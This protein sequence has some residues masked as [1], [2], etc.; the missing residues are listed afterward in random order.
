VALEFISRFDFVVF[1]ILLFKQMNALE[2]IHEKEY[3]HADIKASNLLRGYESANEV[4][5]VD[6]GLAFRYRVADKHTD[7][8]EDPRKVHDGT[9]E[10]T[11]CDAH[12]GVCKCYH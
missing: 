6:Y 8:K 4:Y 1:K 11:S 3:V 9:I 10:F 5:L 7:Y 2:Y 12:K